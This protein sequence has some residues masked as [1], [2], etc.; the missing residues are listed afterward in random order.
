MFFS[1]SFMVS[2]FKF[3]L[4]IHFKYTFVYAVRKC[5]NVIILHVAVQFFQHHLLKKLFS[6]LY[7]L[8]SLVID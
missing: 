3:G 8:G 6:S 2:G 1:G 5:P 7:I 4:F